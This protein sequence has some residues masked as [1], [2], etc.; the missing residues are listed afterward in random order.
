MGQKT[1]KWCDRC[2]KEIDILYDYW[3]GTPLITTTCQPGE[4]ALSFNDK[5]QLCSD[6]VKYMNSVIETHLVT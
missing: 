6:C 5:P 2:K 1:I 3:Y 4:V